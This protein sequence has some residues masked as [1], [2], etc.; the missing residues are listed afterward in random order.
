M[1][2]WREKLLGE[3][4]GNNW[5]NLNMEC[6]LNNAIVSVKFC[7]DDHNSVVT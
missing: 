5:Q 1:F 7:E 3:H 2:D 4:F 6:M